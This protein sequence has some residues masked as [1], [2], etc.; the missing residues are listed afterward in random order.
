MCVDPMWV[1]HSQKSFAIMIRKHNLRTL[2][3]HDVD[4]CMYI[5]YVMVPLSTQ[6]EPVPEYYLEVSKNKQ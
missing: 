4:I 1:V 6:Q 2:F 5:I 3:D